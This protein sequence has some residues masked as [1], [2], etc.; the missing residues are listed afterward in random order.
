MR[1]I[2]ASHHSFDG[3]T[4]G[5][6]LTLS[7]LTSTA[8]YQT[9]DLLTA[10]RVA[11]QEDASL[12]DGGFGPDMDDA[13]TMDAAA[14]TIFKATI[15]HGMLTAGYI[16][17][18]FG[19]EL[20]GPGVIYISQTLNFKGPVKIGDEVIAKVTVAELFPAKRRARFDCPP[21]FCCR[22]WSAGSASRI[23]S[24]RTSHVPRDQTAGFRTRG[25]RNIPPALG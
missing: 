8:S 25:T 4:G 22:P 3:N 11:L 12:D 17:A 20:P 23:P 1:R 21:S 13:S 14:K 5:T 7:Q 10:M 15:A 19:M 24:P 18:V 9:H 16:S 2:A 6:G